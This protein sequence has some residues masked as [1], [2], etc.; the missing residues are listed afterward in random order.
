[1]PLLITYLSK[2]EA[3]AGHLAEKVS[4]WQTVNKGDSG[5]AGGEEAAGVTPC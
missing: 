3:T 1:M 5:R 4:T 2:S